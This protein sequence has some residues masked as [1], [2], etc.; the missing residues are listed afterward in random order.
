MKETRA[1]QVTALGNPILLERMS[2]ALTEMKNLF[3]KFDSNGDGTITREEFIHTYDQ[4]F[5]DTNT[6]EMFQLMKKLDP[7][8]TG[9]RSAK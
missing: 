7:L 2:T 4:L 5:T 8:N 6:P 9:S 1:S 3:K